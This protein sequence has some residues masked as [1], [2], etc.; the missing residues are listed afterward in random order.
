M[1]EERLTFGHGAHAA[2]P[3]AVVAS[4]LAHEPK[5]FR[6]T[7]LE[8]WDWGWGGLLIFSILLFF[9]PQGQIAW[10][11]R[12]H[13]SDLA[14]IV[15]LSA[16][17]FLRISKGQLV[18][19]VTPELIAI[20]AL[21][22]VILLTV[23][24][25]FWPGGSVGV[26]TG[27]FVK[28]FLIFVLMVNTVTSPRRVGRIG[29]V[30]VLAFGYVSARAWLDYFGGTNLVEGDRVRGA[31]GGF[32]S[33]PNDLALNLVTFLP[34]AMI[35]VKRPG[36]FL[37]RVLAAAIVVLMFGAIIFTK[38]RS[39]LVGMV[40]MMAVFLITSRS[41]TPNTI[42]AAVLGG[43]VLLPMLPPT[44]WDRVASI[45]DEQK[46]TTG[47]REER[48]EL[49]QQAWGL[50]LEHPVTGIGA[51]QFKNYGEEGQPREWRVTHNTPLQIA[52][53]IGVFGLVAF[54]FLVWRGFSAAW[55]TSRSLTW[56]HRKRP[57]RR[58]APTPEPEDGLTDQERMFLQTHGAAML[59]AMTGWFVCAMFASVAFN[60]TFY[61]VVGLAVTGRDVVRAR[62]Q[63]YLKAKEVAARALAA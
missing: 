2:V 30:I 63:A 12:M 54:M 53:E 40:A 20:S 8:T 29:W 31:L 32:F 34:L 24:T 9:R 46:D 18:S 62:R 25:S 22:A 42:I 55:E 58:G 47:S 43:M 50:F 13:L 51:G 17:V 35:A 45:T 52:A 4:E 6:F 60:W 14:A 38:S 48:I 41:L 7:H 61:Y 33:N 21:G 23:P 44:F 3:Q 57:R 59:A 5:P 36:R 26:F 39:G 49:M 37:S 10:L 11:G 27:L 1:R 28:V 16:M 15:G 19:R 56:I